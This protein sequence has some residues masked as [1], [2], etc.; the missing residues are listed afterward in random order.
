LGSAQEPIYFLIPSTDLFV[1]TDSVK[2]SVAIEPRTGETT[3]PAATESNTV[4]AV[5]KVNQ[6]VMTVGTAS[7]PRFIQGTLTVP[8]NNPTSSDAYFTHAI[9]TSNLA[10]PNALKEVSVSNDGVFDIA[11]VNPNIRGA[12]CDYQVRYKISDPNAS[13]SITGPISATYS[14]MLNDPPGLDNFS[15]TNFSYKTFNNDGV[16]SFKFDVTFQTVG[17]RSVDGVIVY[18]ESTNDDAD[19]TNDITLILTQL[20]DVKKSSV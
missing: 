20:M 6:Y 9:F 4:V 12:N 11:V 16:S 18:F 5:S 1:Q 10:A 17:T 15:V 19:A 14:V 7:E 3:R 2:V 8:I 13:G